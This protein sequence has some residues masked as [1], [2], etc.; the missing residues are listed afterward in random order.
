MGDIHKY[1]RHK[2]IGD[3]PSTGD[4]KMLWETYTRKRYI[5]N[6]WRHKCRGDIDKCGR[7]AQ[8]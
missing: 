6:Y 2:I 3:I 1:R 5:Q 4:I 8:I 7:H